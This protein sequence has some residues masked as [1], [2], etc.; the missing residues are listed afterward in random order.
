MIT[1]LYLWYLIT[2]PTD[3]L[4]CNLWLSQPPTR[5][6]LV[7]A[8]GTDAVGAFKLDVYY[9]LDD[10]H[11]STERLCSLPYADLVNVLDECR[12]KETLDHYVLYLIQPGVTETLC[13]V[14]LTEDRPVNADDVNAQCPQAITGYVTGAVRAEFIGTQQQVTPEAQTCQ[15]QTV[16]S[17]FDLYSQPDDPKQ[18]WTDDELTWLA[19]RLIWFGIVVPECGGYSG[20]DPDTHA[21]NPCG[22]RF[23]KGKLIEWQNQ[24]NDEIYQA[25][26]T[27]QVPARLLKRM[28]GMES[29]FWPLYFGGAGETGVMQVT[30]NGADVL[31]RYDP[32]LVPWYG[33]VNVESQFYLR[34]E[35]LHNFDCVNCDIT[36]A[37]EKTKALIPMYARLLAAYR[38]RAVSINPA[39][40]GPD[41]WRQSVVDYNG[42]VEYLGRIEE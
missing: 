28:I 26:I 10:A 38:C 31:L 14:T 1:L 4:I 6:Q 18:L 8:C 5:E 40:S 29:Q 27:Y 17:G 12:L 35:A 32:A 19:G 22:L 24:F 20:L 30:E 13:A 2:V 16:P 9:A 42:S 7:A 36:Q 25:A 15:S 37:L 41:A 11:Q 21:A 39:L 23:A 34:M 33:G 3:K